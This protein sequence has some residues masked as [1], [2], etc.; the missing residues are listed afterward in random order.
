M[1]G[2]PMADRDHLSTDEELS[3]SRN[4][5][6]DTKPVT[7]GGVDDNRPPGVIADPSPVPAPRWLARNLAAAQSASS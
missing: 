1:G 7:H 5:P 3:G 2:P 4:R 6:P